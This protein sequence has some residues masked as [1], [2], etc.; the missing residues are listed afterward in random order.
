MSRS[1]WARLGITGLSV[2]L[3]VVMVQPDAVD[4][5]R[6][7]ILKIAAQEQDTLDPHASV[8]AQT[9][10]SVRLVYRGLTK[11]AT[12]DGK[13]WT[14]SVEP[15][16]AESWTVSDDGTVWTF[17]LRKGVQFHKGFG[18]LTA[19]DVRFSFERQMQRK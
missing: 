14:T 6:K 3:V 4:A 5:A 19:E 18:E 16:L 12:K 7:N 15:D 13:V 1:P 10:Q 11:F 8:L 17:T 9:Q 2:F